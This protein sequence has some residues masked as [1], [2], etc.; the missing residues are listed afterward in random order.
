MKAPSRSFNDLED[1]DCI[2]E[3]IQVVEGNEITEM[4]DEDVSYVREDCE[5]ILE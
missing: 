4:D 3:D 2:E 1:H 5:G